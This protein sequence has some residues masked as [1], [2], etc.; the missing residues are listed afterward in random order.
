M[1]LTLFR[2]LAVVL[3]APLERL[4]GTPAR[5]LV[6]WSDSADDVWEPFLDDDTP[7]EVAPLAA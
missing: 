4:A 1:D 7:V 3:L 5:A 6:R 2:S